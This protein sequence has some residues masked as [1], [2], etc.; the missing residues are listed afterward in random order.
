M[1]E[2]KRSF[3]DFIRNATDEEKERVYG[4][5][6]LKS[7]EKQKEITEAY[8]KAREAKKNKLMN[9]SMDDVFE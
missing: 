9:T 3:S 8:E 7:I 1:A 6:I 5:V 2:V 4:E